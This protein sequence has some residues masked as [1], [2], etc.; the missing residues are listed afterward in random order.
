MPGN[1]SATYAEAGVDI[2]AG[3][4]LVERIKPLAAS[5]AR[6]GAA[7]ALGGFGGL[8]DLRA[9]GY[10]D[11]IL[12][13]G[14]DGVGTKLKIAIETGVH[15]TIGI[16]LV[17]MC[18]NDVAVQ[19]AQPLFFLDYFACG[20]LKVDVAASVI[21]GIAEGCRKAGAA[22]IGGET[23]EMPGLY[24]GGDY[25]L[26]GCCVGAAERG[27]LLPRGDIAAGDAIIGVSSSGVHSNGFSL[28]RSIVR[29]EGLAWS[30][31]APFEPGRALGEALLKP[32][33]IYVGAALA[34]HAQ[35]VVKAFAHITG[36][37]LP[38]NVTRVLPSRVRASIDLDHL[39]FTP[40][41]EWLRTAGSVSD[42]EMLRTFNCGIGFIAIAGPEHAASVMGCFR[43]QGHGAVQIGVIENRAEYEPSVRMTGAFNPSA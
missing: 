16:D 18:A 11:P 15:N 33:T 40:V 23:A 17:A 8:F 26:A 32:T 29:K 10:S 24:A 37:G 9:A 39:P 7:A 27:A 38:G 34:A 28:V 25:D 13:A 20:S 21:A 2:D 36:G 14:N 35:G 4:T 43:A 5:T 6:P 42:L 30:S 31:P 22:L 3:D 41:F 19:G 12:V 1:G